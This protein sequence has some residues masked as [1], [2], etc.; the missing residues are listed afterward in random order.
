MQKFWRKR[1]FQYSIA[2]L[3]AFFL[4]LIPKWERDKKDIPSPRFLAGDT[5]SCVVFIK[6]SIAVKGYSLG[7]I[8]ELFGNLDNSQM[9]HTDIEPQDNYF[10]SWVKL[11]TGKSDILII[12]ALRDT[13]PEIF[14]EEVVSSIPINP[15]D[16][17]LVVEKSNYQFIQIFNHWFTFFKH[18]PEYKE[19]SS[20][21]F[22]SYRSMDKEGGPGLGRHL[23]PYD[24]TIRENSHI[25][26]WDWRLLASL[27]Y[28]ESKFKAGVS[29]SRGAIGLM[30]IKEAVAQKYGI[31]DI[32]NPS[33]NI[34]AGTLHLNRL[35]KMYLKMGADS[36][37]ARQ[38]AIAAYNC[39]EGRMSDCMNLATQEGKNPLLWSDI[40]EIIPL[41]RDE[42][43][44]NSPTV[45][46]GRFNGKETLK[47]VEKIEER[48]LKYK[49][50]AP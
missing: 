2:F 19:L 22:R 26:G 50:T 8:Y 23:S 48:Y 30:Q 35:Q 29:S 4:F 31:D 10:A 7:Y 6:N 24:Q 47:Y 32:Y 20:K 12:N 14:Q 5:L 13:V 3:G 15:S 41:L 43:Y 44:Y 46:Y 1:Y 28:Q 49:E 16:D 33:D 40:K 17:I 27:I 36:L 37:N 21:F 9:C 34:K 42:K 39:G 25:L 11:A 38:I 45:K 18:T